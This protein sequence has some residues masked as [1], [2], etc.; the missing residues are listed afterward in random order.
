MDYAEPPLPPEEGF[1]D[2]LAVRDLAGGLQLL[3]LPVAEATAA[4]TV[5]ALLWFFSVYGAPL[6]LKMDNGAPFVAAATR[7]LLA[8][9]QVV[10]LFSPPR[11]PP[12]NGAME[13]G[14][15]SLKART[16][17]QAVGQGHPGAWT[18]ADTEAARQQA[19]TLARP[20][21]AHQPTPAERW[22]DRGV[23]TA[24]ERSA[25]AATVARLEA[26]ERASSAGT[27]AAPE[28]AAPTEAAAPGAA[29]RRSAAQGV[30]A[31]PARPAGRHAE[32]G[33][34]ACAAARRAVPTDTKPSG[35][36]GPEPEASTSGRKSLT[37]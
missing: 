34:P 17:Y 28:A 1:T 33:A 37:V 32:R 23:L 6:V 2:L 27:A 4:T 24:G 21:G 31:A 20:W 12:Y 9:W 14:I 30:P 15:G 13:A 11:L 3:W 5:A 16:H 19:N 36:N 26:E 10:P 25:F 18:L 29:D 7:A 22:A 8:Q 35:V